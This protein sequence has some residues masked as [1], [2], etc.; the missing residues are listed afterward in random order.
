ME[1]IENSKIIV[2]DTSREHDKV[3]EKYV[4][5]KGIYNEKQNYPELVVEDILR[6][7]KESK[8]PEDVLRDQLYSILLKRGINKWLFVRK[9]LIR[10]KKKYQHK[11]R[12]I[13]QKLKDAP[14]DNKKYW[15][16]KGE[17]KAYTEIR[18]E[19]MLLCNTPRWVIWNYKRVGLIDMTGL[20]KGKAKK[21]KILFDELCNFKFD[22]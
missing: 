3:T 21:W 20:Q 17:L 6:L 13:D 11:I 7:L 10:L 9:L 2:W 19:L 8:D 14:M 16:L 5:K 22:R 15:K 4:D 18:K 12:E 1:A